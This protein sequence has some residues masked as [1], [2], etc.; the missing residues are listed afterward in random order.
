MVPTWNRL[1]RQVF[2]TNVCA[3]NSD[4][5]LLMNQELRL[6]VSANLCMEMSMRDPFLKRRLMWL[7]PLIIQ[8]SYYTEMKTQVQPSNQEIM[9]ERFGMEY[10]LRRNGIIAL[11]DPCLNYH[12]MFP[13]ATYQNRNANRR[14][15]YLRGAPARNQKECLFFCRRL[16]I[17]HNH[18][19]LLR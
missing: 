6:T 8:W 2:L 3:G 18:C 13:C 4:L 17:A 7:H 14:R 1:K 5:C 19:Q 11:W 15:S 16:E 10:R 12:P 9:L